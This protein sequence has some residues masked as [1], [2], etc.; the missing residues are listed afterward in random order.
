MTNDGFW[1]RF[2]D[3][4]CDYDELLKGA[5]SIDAVLLLALLLASPGIERGSASFVILVLN[6]AL[7][8]PLLFVTLYLLL[9]CRR[10]DRPERF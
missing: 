2:W 9:W 1:I 3:V 7:L 10:R 5:L 4:V 6:V 8:V